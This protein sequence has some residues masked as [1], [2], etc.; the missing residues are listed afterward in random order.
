MKKIILSAAIAA[1]ALISAPALAAATDGQLAS[2]D[3]G[4]IGSMTVTTNIPKLVKI[5]GLSDL[6]FNPTAAQLSD[7]TG[8]QNASQRFCVYSNDT[9]NGLY[10]VRVDGLAGSELNTGEL[11]FGLTG[12]GGSILDLG[13]W[14][15]DQ[16][17]NAMIRGTARP[18]QE[19][20]N[21][22]TTS[23]GQSR[24]TNLTCNGQNNASLAF[25]L[26]IRAFWQ[27]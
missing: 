4:S 3:T 6:S 10:K 22:A 5:S 21:F 9:V 26:K 24:P 18:G 11:K 25:R 8:L 7:G 27:L 20:Q 17:N 16:A 2:V 14:V 19:K 13:V 1:S 23:G 15:S 12:P